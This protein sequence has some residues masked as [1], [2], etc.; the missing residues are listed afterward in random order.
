M[1]VRAMGSKCVPICAIVA[2]M[3]AFAGV[4]WPR[5]PPS[6]RIDAPSLLLVAIICCLCVLAPLWA[7]SSGAGL[8]AEVTWL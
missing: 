3:S 6:S 2:G 7:A 4:A 1:K 8:G 5:E